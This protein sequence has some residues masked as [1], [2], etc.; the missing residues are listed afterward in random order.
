MK[1]FLIMLILILGTS[2]LYALD[3]DTEGTDNYPSDYEMAISNAGGIVTDFSELSDI[4]LLEPQYGYVNF[5]G[6]EKMPTTKHSDYQGWLEFFDGQGNYF[7]KR[8]IVNAQGTSSMMYVKKNFNIDLCDDEWI[9]DAKPTLTIGD[10]VSLDSFN[11]KA[12]YTDYFRG[13]AVVSYRFFDA[14]I[15]DRGDMAHP[16]QRAGV[17][18][19]DKKA[20]CHPDGFPVGVYLNGEFYGVYSW[21]IKKHRKNLGLIKDCAEHINLDGK[22]TDQFFKG[23]IDW[24]QFEIRNPKTLYCQDGSIY[25]GDYPKEI[26]DDTSEYYDPDNKNHV[27]SNQVKQYI[28]N[29]TTYVPTL[30]NMCTDGQSVEDIRA[31]FA[32][33]F[34]VQGFIDYTV[35]SSVVNN[36]DGW[37]KNWQWITYD[38]KKWFVE[39]YDL[40]MTFGNTWYGYATTPPEVQH[41]FNKPYQRFEFNT[42]PA[43][44]VNRYF[45]D[46][47]ESRYAHLRDNGTIDTNS[48]IDHVRQW[49]YRVGEENYAREYEKWSDSYCN[50]EMIIDPNWQLYDDFTQYQ[51]VGDWDASLTYQEGD[52]C[53]AYDMVWVAKNEVTG[54]HPCPQPGYIDSLERVEDWIERR[55]AME[56]VLWNYNGSQTSI[57]DVQES[58]NEPLG[59]IEAIYDVNGHRISKLQ[60]GI[61]IVRYS[62]GTISKVFLK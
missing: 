51:N 45:A 40:D 41:F 57:K 49:Y 27:L 1:Q 48:I 31:A 36:V 4:S 61:N 7:K 26:M 39:P 10:W 42:G 47:L 52:L 28:L 15:A 50:R 44:Y 3:P 9:G 8:V 62:N 56:D 17:V 46:D 58:Q 21:Q 11:L 24:T 25:D 14:V 16:W 22:I 20:R 23:E 34:D 33:M 19:A 13:L 2:R 29:L 55:V 30:S 54:I 32:D 53:R 38:G 43:Y 18:T 37:E 60:P 35:F 59:E 6:F 5:S 12:Y